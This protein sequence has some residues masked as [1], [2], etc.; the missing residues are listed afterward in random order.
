MK[1][2][3]LESYN[4]LEYTDVPDPSIGSEDVLIRVK[5]CGICGSDVHGMDGSTH[6]RQP[7][8]IMGHEAAGVIE[9][10]GK[11]VRNFRVGQSVT[12]DSTI[13]CGKCF[14]C[15]SGSTS[16]CDHRKVLG[17]A[18]DEYRHDGAFAEWVALPQHIVHHLPDHMPF[19]HAA[20]TEPISVALHAVKKAN[21]QPDH[22]V[23]VVGA[24]I[25]GLFIIQVLRYIGCRKIIALDLVNSR[26]DL[27]KQLG[28]DFTLNAD[29]SDLVEQIDSITDQQGIHTSFEVVGIPKTVN[30]ALTPLKKGGKIILV[31]NLT[32]TV[33][34]PLQNIIAREITLQGSYA[35]GSSFPQAIELIAQ[36]K[37]KVDPIISQIAPLE[38][39]SS[40]FKR[41]YDKQP[42]L[43]KVI[44]TP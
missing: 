7:P 44:L 43:M 36:E 2:L 23:L 15:R 16:L 11:N 8:L 33:D 22:D 3:V 19:N 24:G 1:A 6:R 13:Y 42:N 38:E 5:A 26:L 28:A 21:L 41:L 32:P 17:V 34:I 27:A 4:H 37:I 29:S 18:C 12:F 20:M 10:T 14:Y 35:T 25:I 9:Q 40:W 31:G 39:G 30:L